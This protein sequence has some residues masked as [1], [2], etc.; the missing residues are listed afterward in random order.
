[1]VHL[2]TR[3]PIW[4]QVLIGYTALVGVLALREAAKRAANLAP[5]SLPVSAPYDRGHVAGQ[6]A[7][8]WMRA[9]TWFIG[10]ALLVTGAQ[11]ALTVVAVGYA[12]SARRGY[13]EYAQ[14]FAEGRKAVQLASAHEYVAGRVPPDRMAFFAAG[15]FITVTRILP[16]GATL[17]AMSWLRR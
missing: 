2:L 17:V 6:Q 3:W 13:G 15:V 5:T 10:A 7:A 9:L 16:L 12:I 11:W 14:G 8:I 4:Y 1:M